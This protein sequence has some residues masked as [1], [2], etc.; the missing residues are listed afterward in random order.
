MYIMVAYQ[1]PATSTASTDELLPVGIDAFG[2]SPSEPITFQDPFRH[3]RMS[4][5]SDIKRALDFFQICTDYS[6]VF[7]HCSVL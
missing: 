6:D 2:R 3:P 4:Q 1:L 5:G 7:E